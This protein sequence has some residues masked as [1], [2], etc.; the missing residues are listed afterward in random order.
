LAYDENIWKRE[1]EPLPCLRLGDYG[2][3]FFA[4]TIADQIRCNW[5]E[6]ST[7]RPRN[8]ICREITV[9]DMPNT[10]LWPDDPTT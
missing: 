8:S 7:E 2:G 4:V 1:R 5:V 10:V 6:L 3:R 9:S